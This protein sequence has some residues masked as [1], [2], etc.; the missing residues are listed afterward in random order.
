MIQLFL[1]NVPIDLSRLE[2]AL[3]DSDFHTA[4]AIAHKIKSSFH[5]MGIDDTAAHLD[6]L[7]KLLDNNEI[8]DA[9]NLWV[10]IDKRFW[11]VYPTLF[12]MIEDY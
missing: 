12:R 4:K 2:L 11:R 6:E 1:N 5:I 7:K 10:K 9:I 8:N 3:K